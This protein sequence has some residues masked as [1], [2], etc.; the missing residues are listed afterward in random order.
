MIQFLSRI[1]QSVL[2]VCLL[3]ASIAALP[4]C[5]SAQA[6]LCSK[7]PSASCCCD[8]SPQASD[9]HL[10]CA[11]T[12]PF[13]LTAAVAQPVVMSH[14]AIAARIAQ[15]CVNVSALHP[16][17]P[18]RYGP[19]TFGRAAPLARYLLYCTFRL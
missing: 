17:S 3:R 2:V 12:T 9:H 15:V 16:S 19:A 8:A 7:A 6:V 14:P 11:Q 13:H 5:A 10:T 4:R 18:A 1:V